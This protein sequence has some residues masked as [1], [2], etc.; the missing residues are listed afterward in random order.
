MSKK[1]LKHQAEE[2]LQAE[3]MHIKGGLDPEEII[4]ECTSCSTCLSGCSPGCQK[5][6]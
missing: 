5:K 3:L 6:A 2:L 4:D 1:F